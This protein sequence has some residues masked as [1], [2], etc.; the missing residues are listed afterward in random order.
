MAED[1]IAKQEARDAGRDEASEK[2]T[3]EKIMG[4]YSGRQWMWDLLAF[5]GPY[6]AR[7]LG[8]GDVHGAIHRDG[9]AAVGARLIDMIDR[10]CPDR[11]VEMVREHQARLK[12]KRDLEAQKGADPADEVPVM[13]AIE[14]MG[15]AQEAKA[16]AEAAAEKA[17]K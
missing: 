10:H 16:E 11:Y 7:Y 15:E 5:T 4:G 17:K 12:R 13:T 14:R 2:Q 9:R 6:Q 8:D 3:I 1:R